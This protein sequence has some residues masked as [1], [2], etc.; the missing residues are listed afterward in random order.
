MLLKSLPKRGGCCFVVVAWGSFDGRFYDVIFNNR[1]CMV[2]YIFV[3]SL[4][5]VALGSFLYLVLMFCCFVCLVIPVSKIFPLVHCCLANL[6]PA[7]F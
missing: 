2:L 1:F 4:I 6:Q 3:S 5:I 7:S